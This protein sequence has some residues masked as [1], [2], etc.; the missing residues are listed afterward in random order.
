MAKKNN[1]VKSDRQLIALYGWA[2]V[3]KALLRIGALQRDVKNVEASAQKEIDKI[4]AGLA[5]TVK[6][7]QDTVTLYT[8]SIEAW[9]VAHRKELGK[10][11][12]RK[13][14]HGTV[15]WR[16]S[17]KVEVRNNAKTLEL[18]KQVFGKNAAQYIHVKETP[19]KE[20]MAKLKDEQ[21]ATLKARRNHKE[22]FFVE[23]DIV[24][25][26]DHE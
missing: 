17:S 18:I 16:K 21:L 24:E 1:R 9:V 4:K 8:E 6:T 13:L 7:A 5:A 10:A 12:S 11:Q 22:V 20:A 14:N 19:D 26:A 25:A 23:P 2:S 15:G 3:D